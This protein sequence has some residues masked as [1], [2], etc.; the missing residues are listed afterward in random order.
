[1]TKGKHVGTLS[2]RRRRELERN[3][4]DGAE[5]G[6]KKDGADANA[7]CPAVASVKVRR[8]CNSRACAWHSCS[9]GLGIAA[10]CT[11]TFFKGPANVR[12]VYALEG[13]SKDVMPGAEVVAPPRHD[14][15]PR[16]ARE[17]SPAR[18]PP[19]RSG[20]S[21]RD[22]ARKCAQKCL[23]RAAAPHANQKMQMRADVRKVVYADPEAASHRPKRA[24][25]GLLVPAQRPRSARPVAREDNVHGAPGADRA[26]ELAAAA[27]NRAAVYRP[28][29]LHLDLVGEE[30]VLHAKMIGPRSGQGNVVAVDC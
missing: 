4:A 19:S 30:S 12:P 16:Q 23:K 5:F 17:K 7:Q 10:A 3:L 11:G 21:A 25:H 1:M 13:V 26:L 20:H 15:R 22:Y 18:P 29:E 27:S 24:S 14:P 6:L 8:R 28:R 9:R 2:Q